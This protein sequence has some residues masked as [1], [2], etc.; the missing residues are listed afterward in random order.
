VPPGS[1]RALALLL[2]SAPLAALA[3]ARPGPDTSRAAEP[4]VHESWTVR[5]GLPVNSVTALV[6]DQRGY[7]WIATF[8]GLAR[9]D[10]VRFTVF[11]AA[12]SPGLPSNRIIRLKETR[13]GA[14]WLETEQ[15]QLV[16][17]RGGAFTAVAPARTA[18][19][20]LLSLEE[21]RS[22][23]LWV[24]SEMGLGVV[25]GDSVVA[26]APDVIQGAVAA[27]IARRDGSVWAATVRGGVFRIVGER[28]ER[29]IPAARFDGDSVMAL[30]EDNG[31]GLWI[32]SSGALWRWRD[33]LERVVRSPGDGFGVLL[34]APSAREVWAG[35]PTRVYRVDSGGVARVLGT[36]V[37]GRSF[38]H[39]LLFPDRSGHT[40]FF[41]GRP[42][43]RDRRGLAGARP[44]A[45]ALATV[46]A[47][48]SGTVIDHEGSLWI[49]T[50]HHGLHR[51]KP[52]PVHIVA[53]VPGVP[54]N[55]VYPVLAARDGSVWY[56]AGASVVRV[57]NGQARA[58][59]RAVE[60]GD[61]AR[62]LLE[63]GSGRVWVGGTFPLEVCTARA[64]RCAPAP[65]AP[66]NV[67]AMY[68]D[69]DGTVWAGTLGGLFRGGRGA[70]RR[71][72]AADGAPDAP[73]RVIQRTRD[74][75][76]WM[77]T[78]GG[79]LALWKDGR[80]RSVTEADGL[81]SDLV[82]S[83]YEDADGWLW[84]GTEGHGLARLDPREWTG[85]RLRAGGHRGGHIVAIGAK[86]G[87]FDDAVHQ[88]LED[89]FGR[90]WMNG[91]RGISWVERRDLLAF[92]AGRLSRLDATSYTE[93]DGLRNR[94]GNG[95][96]QPAGARTRDGRLWLPTQ[97]G[98]A[99]IDPA[100]IRRNL[101]PPPVAIE[102]VVAGRDT[103]LVRG[104][105]LS[106]GT[107]RRD[108][109]LMYT[110]LSFLAP[111]NVR[112]RYRL[113][114][115]DRDWVDAGGRRTAFYT[116]VPPGRYTFRVIASN[117]DGVW[118][119]R[120]AA[121][122]LDVRPS[123]WETTT[124][125]AAVAATL[126]GL[127]ALGVHWRLRNLRARAAQ[128]ER[129]VD[130]RTAALRE[131]ERELAERNAQLQSLDRAKTRFFANVS[132]ELRT[133]LTLT[134]G[135]LE[136]LRE[137]L[138]GGTGV[139]APRQLD[140]ALRNA[141]RLLRLVN[142]ILDVAKLEAGH[143]PLRAR[144][145]D[146]AAF[147][148]GVAA[149]F[150]AAAE[151]REVTLEV[152]V[153]VAP[154]TAWFDPD[155]MEKVLVN[156][157][158]NALTF[159]PPGGRVTLLVTTDGGDGGDGGGV[160][161]LRVSDTGPG[162]RAEH[163]PH[164]FERFYQADESATRAQPGTGIG[165]SLVKELVELHGGRIAVWSG[166]GLPREGES[167]ATGGGATF[168]VTLPPGRAHLGDDQ[169]EDSPDPAAE[170]TS[171][172]RATYATDALT[173][174]ATAPAAEAPPE[175]G[176]PAGDDATTLLVVDDSADL[177]SWIRV[178]FEPRYRVIEAADGLQGIAV[179][180]ASLPDLVI[181]DVV[182]PGA[183][184]RALCRAL[185]ES[186]ETDFIPVVLL[187]ARAT[188]EDRVSGL[189]G[190]ADDYVAKPFDMRE[191][192]ARVDNLIASRRRLRTRFAAERLASAGGITGPA[193]PAATTDDQAWVER[194][195]AT[196]DARLEEPEFG[197]TELADAMSVDR[198]HLFRRAR[199]LLGE[200]P[201]ALL[202]RRRLERAASLL[203]S[204]DGGVGEIAYA[205]G[206]NSVAHFCRL[207]RGTYGATPSAYRE[208][209]SVLR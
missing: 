83:L 90:L 205:C 58:V 27:V 207:F 115:Y 24:G 200:S 91:N 143:M 28:A 125:R 77:G 133:P 36:G 2:L 187:T 194:L 150:T 30:L 70:W 193:A 137:R 61:W 153:A 156:L 46:A 5:D 177:R 144:R 96:S 195:G 47:E 38:W 105:S 120:G 169:V 116:R 69:A 6:Q 12:S 32:G 7:L 66:T 163:L 75:A 45:D 167:S 11:K 114:P 81:P 44:Y 160:A 93:R 171:A 192:A 208:A 40:L 42:L 129:V 174:A 130:E 19:G 179:A 18:G 197:V 147:A 184:G 62:S 25:R 138:A 196:I 21:G 78:A 157:L 97:D 51:L 23:T 31:G 103:L 164:V 188:T 190:G 168:T 203:A 59:R 54:S 178:H 185:K 37:N 104:T 176:G 63:D 89:A 172:E 53:D 106:L 14:L 113:E 102:H 186:A 181:S 189:E 82:R 183:D 201:S 110:A 139:R 34:E 4:F 33:S 121:L 57:A 10:G 76:L 49:G 60:V 119:E 145:G 67:L 134:I 50:Y 68:E 56:G 71:L 107:W 198:T 9:F 122:A 43:G 84:V 8:D 112:F 154:L 165:L 55:E 118:N 127:A 170:P 100:R 80:F 155:A 17:V 158:A 26:V 86:D 74:G 173:T 108:L 72:T 16:R 109:E 209:R 199:E 159:T 149:A 140:L 41:D 126:L 191:L 152:V 132:H 15:H 206:F 135:P 35:T 111:A 73:V 65:G 141:R 79:G 131:H 92:A 48:I 182:M 29:V 162:I 123:V 20:R 13:D 166:A 124:F 151:R 95:G 142:Q 202:R 3:Q 88:V 22:G 117:N 94:E 204:G 85:A 1:S 146:L 39:S 52:T 101:A 99:V 87:L 136:D 128:L 161:V 98:V 64:M 175:G 148:R 180:R